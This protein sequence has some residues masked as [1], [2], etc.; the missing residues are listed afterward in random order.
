MSKC[1]FGKEYVEYLT[2][3]IFK[4]WLRVDPNNIKEIKERIKPANI[5]RLRWLLALNLY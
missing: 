3:I 2:H 4:W 5:S 1:T